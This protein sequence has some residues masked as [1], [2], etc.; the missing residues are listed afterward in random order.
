MCQVRH[1]RQPLLFFLIHPGAA[2][3][4][5]QLH[6]VQH[7][8]SS[9]NGGRAS[10]EIHFSRG[11]FFPHCR[12]ASSAMVGRTFPSFRQQLTLA[13]P[14]PAFI[15]RTRSSGSAPAVF[16]ETLRRSAN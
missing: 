11:P 4:T 8:T 14:P 7:E 3:H 6:A 2:A 9:P 15:A 13:F 12:Y 5:P 10:C 16:V 1:S